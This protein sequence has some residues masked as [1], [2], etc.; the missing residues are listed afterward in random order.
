MKKNWLIPRKRKVLI[1]NSLE[2]GAPVEGRRALDRPFAN[3]VRPVLGGAAG[4]L[5]EQGQGH[6]AGENAQAPHQEEGGAPAFGLLGEGAHDGDENDRAHPR[7]RPEDTEGLPPLG[8]R[9]EVRRDGACYGLGRD[10]ADGADGVKNE[11]LLEAPG[12]AR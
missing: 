7:D 4:G 2:G 8:P 11:E 1:L 6:E 5:L 9:E 10:G 3:P 12:K